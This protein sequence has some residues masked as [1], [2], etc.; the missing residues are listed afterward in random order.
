MEETA[1]I[2]DRQSAP[3]RDDGGRA[4]RRDDGSSPAKN[5]LP[6]RG[7]LTLQYPT[8]P[9]KATFGLVSRYKKGRTIPDGNTQFHFNTAGFRFQSTSYEWLVVA[10]ARAQY[11]GVGEVNG[12]GG[13][14]FMVTVIDG[15]VF[16]QPQADKFRIKIWE[17]GTEVIIYD[18]QLGADD[19][20]DPSTALGGGSVQIHDNKN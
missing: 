9:G 14:G 20:A 5:G 2:Q 11:K 8:S 17:I 3:G 1:I 6:G 18:N 10:G 12:Q 16:Q 19:S 7:A 4:H 13:Y 15:D